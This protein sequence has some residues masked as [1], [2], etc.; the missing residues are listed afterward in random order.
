MERA[1]ET[2]HHLVLM[3]R[4]CGLFG[5]GSDSLGDFEVLLP[6]YH[7]S[8]A[9]LT[10]EMSKVNSNPQEIVGPKHCD[11]WYSEHKISLVSKVD[12]RCIHWTL[13]E[14]QAESIEADLDRRLKHAKVLLGNGGRRG[15]QT[16]T[17]MKGEAATYPKW[18]NKNSEF[19]GV[20]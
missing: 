8:P 16:R 20:Q 5:K 13:N 2:L 11:F 18:F 14:A 6:F 7:L 3:M 15:C 19:A 9:Q 12:V 10:S 1:V 4:R 17:T